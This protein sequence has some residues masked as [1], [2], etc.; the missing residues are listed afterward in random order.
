[1][2]GEGEIKSNLFKDRVPLGGCWRKAGDRRACR[3]KWGWRWGGVEME[4]EVGRNVMRGAEGGGIEEERKKK[5][6]LVGD[7]DER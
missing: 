7:D 1:M 2:F 5:D 6:L 4:M 3:R